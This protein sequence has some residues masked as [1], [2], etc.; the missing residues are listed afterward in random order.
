MQNILSGPKIGPQ[1]TTELSRTANINV[2]NRGKRWFT[3]CFWC[4]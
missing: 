1:I 3:C 4:V 2:Q